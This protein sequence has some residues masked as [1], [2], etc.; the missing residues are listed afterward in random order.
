MVTLKVATTREY[1]EN[2][3]APVLLYFLIWVVDTGIPFGK[4]HWVVQ[5]WFV[6]FISVKSLL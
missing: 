5:V 1:K 4:S 2:S 3:G 6:Y